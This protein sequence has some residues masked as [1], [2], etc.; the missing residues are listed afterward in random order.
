MNRDVVTPLLRNRTMAIDPVYHLQKLLEDVE[1]HNDLPAFSL[2]KKGKICTITYSFFTKRLKELLDGAGF[3]P[4]L[5]SGHSFQRG[6]A[7]FL[8]QLGCD[9]LIIQATG[10]WKSDAFLLYLSMTFEQ[11]WQAR[12]KMSAYVPQ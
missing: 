6:G 10:D 12:S 3:V 1:L 4:H 7:S 8:F 11:R 5:F 9:L 2:V